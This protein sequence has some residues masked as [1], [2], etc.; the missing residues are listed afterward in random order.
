LTGLDPTS[1]LRDFTVNSVTRGRTYRLR[2]RVL[3]A[4]D[5]SDYSSNLFAL[6]ATVPSAPPIPSLGSATGS[7]ITINFSESADSGGSKILTYELWMD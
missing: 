6:V 1:M 7:T 2:Y 5:W 3:N 4:V